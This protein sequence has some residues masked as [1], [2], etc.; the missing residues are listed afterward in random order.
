ME[1]HDVNRLL[2]RLIDGSISREDFA[3]LQGA[4]RVNPEIRA[5]YYDLIGVDLMLSERYEVPTHIS[6]QAKTMEDHWV[7]RR[8]KHKVIRIAFWAAA[9]CV[10]LTLGGTYLF[11]GQP[12]AATLS[13]SKEC[14][15]TIA[16]VRQPIDTDTTLEKDQE[17]VVTNGLLSMD[18]GTHVKVV[19]EAPARFRLPA[20]KGKLDLQ[21]GSAFL[22]IQ[23]GGKGFE[24][25][26]P[27]GGTLRD[28]GTQF[29]VNVSSTK[30]VEVHVIDGTVGI[31]R[32]ADG[33][34]EH[35]I[36]AGEMARW[37]GKGAIQGGLGTRGRF[38][39]SL[40]RD[41]TI[42]DDD[43]NEADGTKID[44]KMP[45]I[46][47]PW[48]T[49]MEINPSTITGG[50]LDTSK[51]P[52]SLLARFK[53]GQTTDRKVYIVTFSTRGP[54]NIWDKAAFPDAAERITFIRSGNAGPAFSLVARKS[55]DHHW[56]IKD[57]I[58]PENDPTKYS[59]GTRVSALSEADITLSYDSGTGL[60]SLYK[61]T[62]T[63]G[64]LIDTP[65]QVGSGHSLDSLVVSND[66]GGDVS[67]DDLKVRML[68]YQ[69]DGGNSSNR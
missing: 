28:I 50:R 7:V 31:V 58:K 21:E 47:L 39:E 69:Q 56:Q 6:V 27:G 1:E 26:T 65:F 49:Q 66:G 57:E 54:A 5:E 55:R 29:G 61:G 68:T 9:A 44:G 17:V 24:V 48:V 25:L 8:S 64:E 38:A 37:T 33:K 43:F 30:Q 23:P 40:P 67:L 14:I 35:E 10:L 3:R 12:S 52:R 16:G 63:K 46:G 45:D 59:I 11:R 51:G 15:Y 18:I 42:F 20:K 22:A 2:N 34:V 13:A 32:E 36:R 62:D 19:V 53:G 60:V 4:M 41:V